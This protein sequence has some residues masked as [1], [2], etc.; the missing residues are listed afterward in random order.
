MSHCFSNFKAATK[1]QVVRISISY[2]KL[3]N[4]LK[5]EQTDV[6]KHPCRQNFHETE[7]N[8]LKKG[9]ITSETGRKS[10]NSQENKEACLIHTWGPNHS[11]GPRTLVCKKTTCMVSHQW[12]IFWR[13]CSDV[14]FVR[15]GQRRSQLE[16][17]WEIVWRFRKKRST[18]QNVWISEKVEAKLRL[19]VPM[20]SSTRPPLGCI[21]GSSDCTTSQGQHGK[22]WRF[23]TKTLAIHWKITVKQ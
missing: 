11:Y 7:R 4:A 2:F 18:I 21:C 22:V 5:P 1:K 10:S 19:S 14:K 23:Y 6:V 9:P 17:L 20:N 3:R 8:S 16:R 13:V 15:N 12:T